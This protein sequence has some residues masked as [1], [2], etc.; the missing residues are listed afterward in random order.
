[1][2]RSFFHS[3]N[4]LTCRNPFGF[5]QPQRSSERTQNGVLLRSDCTADVTAVFHARRETL[6]VSR[7]LIATTS[8]PK[9]N[10]SPAAEAWA[11]HLL[12]RLCPLRPSEAGG[13]RHEL[14]G[15]LITLSCLL[16]KAWDPAARTQHIPAGGYKSRPS[17]SSRKVTKPNPGDENAGAWSLQVSTS[18]LTPR[19]PSA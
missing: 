2:G 16:H 10:H 17:Q 4:G 9:Y 1:M 19:T 12:C 15:S 18:A 11:W 7:P 14:K 5:C 3:L 8:L 13:P 6:A